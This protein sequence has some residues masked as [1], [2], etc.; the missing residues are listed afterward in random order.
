MFVLTTKA[1]LI[2]VNQTARIYLRSGE[3]I[4]PAIIA[5]FGLYEEDGKDKKIT[6]ETFEMDE[7]YVARDVFDQLT[8]SMDGASDNKIIN[9]ADISKR[10]KYE[11]Q[12][13]KQYTE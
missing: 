1:G 5:S 8:F 2:N 11:Y 12:T 7:L 4:Y 13:G 3:N 6:L 9:L 10:A